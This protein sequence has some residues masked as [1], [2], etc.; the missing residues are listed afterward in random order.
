MSLILELS[1]ANYLDST[2]RLIVLLGVRTYAQR[3]RSIRRSET[4]TGVAMESTKRRHLLG[5]TY[6]LINPKL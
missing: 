2:I 6:H 4:L 3:D 5:I 1:D